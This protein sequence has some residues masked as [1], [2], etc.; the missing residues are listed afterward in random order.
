MVDV[1]GVRLFCII[2]RI[3]SPL[4]SLLIPLSLLTS[5]FPFIE[6]LDDDDDIGGIVC[7]DIGNVD[8]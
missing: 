6:G 3:T 1:V 4:I 2:E 5:S 8:G 7:D